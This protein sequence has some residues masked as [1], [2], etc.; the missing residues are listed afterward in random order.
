MCGG[1]VDDALSIM[2]SGGG[3]CVVRLFGLV[4]AGT[5]CG[6]ESWTRLY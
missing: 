5:K 4:A 6:N 1:G 2:T 3:C